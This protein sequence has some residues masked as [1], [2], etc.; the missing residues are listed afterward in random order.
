MIKSLKKKSS[1]RRSAM[2]AIYGWI[3]SNNDLNLIEQHYLEERNPNNFDVNYFKLL[4]HSIPK[5]KNSLEQSIV[6]YSNRSIDQLDPI[7]Y[8][9]LLIASYELIFCLDIPF[10]VVIS[11]ALE[12]A[13]MFGN[14]TS[15]KFINAVVDRL[16]RDCRKN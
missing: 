15:Y 12:L 1:A 3:I 9:I 11:E 14:E 16:A 8:S 4:L 6:K 7:E 5:E 13:S 10:K 2:Q